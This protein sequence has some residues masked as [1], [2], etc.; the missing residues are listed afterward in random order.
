MLALQNIR[1]QYI[2]I[3]ITIS[4]CLSSCFFNLFLVELFI[5]AIFLFINLEIAYNEKKK[6][7]DVLLLTCGNHTL[8]SAGIV[9]LY[10]EI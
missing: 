7:A 2:Y 1:A 9:I 6:K 5:Q 3:S 10:K 8:T 4:I